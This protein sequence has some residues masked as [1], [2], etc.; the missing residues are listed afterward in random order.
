MRGLFRL[1]LNPLAPGGVPATATPVSERRR[2]C[3]VRQGRRAPSR[4]SDRSES[5]RDQDN[6]TV[7]RPMPVEGGMPGRDREGGGRFH[8]PTAGAADAAQRTWAMLSV[9]AKSMPPPRQSQESGRPREPTKLFSGLPSTPARA[10]RSAVG[11]GTSRSRTTVSVR[12]ERLADSPVTAEP[13]GLRSPPDQKLVS[14]KRPRPGRPSG[15]LR[16]RDAEIAKWTQRGLDHEACRRGIKRSAGQ[17]TLL[18]S[19]ILV[20]DRSRRQVLRLTAQVVRGSHTLGIAYVN[21]LTSPPWWR[22]GN[23]GD[24]QV[25]R[26]RILYIQS[27]TANGPHPAPAEC[28]QPP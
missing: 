26:N 19:G 10:S 22:V 3:R 17:R 20:L 24:P 21:R 4:P 1:W 18:E 2:A 9:G 7:G 23:P 13:L 25:S 16:S 6:V 14:R 8:D 12:R 5:G 28:G 11:R 27:V 15:T